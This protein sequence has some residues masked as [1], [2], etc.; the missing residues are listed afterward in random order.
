[1]LSPCP[2][3]NGHPT[4][5]LYLLGRINRY[6]VRSEVQLQHTKTITRCYTGPDALMVSV[7]G[8]LTCKL[9]PDRVLF[10]MKKYLNL[11][12]GDYIGT[13]PSSPRLP[14]SKLLF[15][16]QALY[17]INTFI[18][19]TCNYEFAIS[20][21]LPPLLN[22]FSPLTISVALDPLIQSRRGRGGRK[23]SHVPRVLPPSRSEAKV[24]L[25]QPP[26]PPPPPPF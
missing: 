18:L 12:P 19:G 9:K 13:I 5:S 23:T 8:S 14:P 21:C 11:Q 2:Q 16:M 10:G 15:S 26:N 20:Y 6:P 1:M 24:W 7:L 17:L 25:T 3:E 22:F 4:G